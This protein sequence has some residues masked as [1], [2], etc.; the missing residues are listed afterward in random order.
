MTFATRTLRAALAATVMAGGLALSPLAQADDDRHG[1][2]MMQ[3]KMDRDEMREMMRNMDPDQRRQMMRSMRGQRSGMMGQQGGP[4]MMMSGSGMMRG[5]MMGPGMMGG[6]GMMGQ[7]GM[8]GP[9]M[10]GQSGMMGPGMMGG[11][12][13]MGPGMMSGMG[14]MGPMMGGGMMGPGMMQGLSDEKQAELTEMRQDMRRQHMEAML[15]MMAIRDEMQQA[16]VADRPDPARIRELHD[17]MAERHGK[18]LEA[19]I[20]M[21]NQMRDFM[22]T[23]Q[24]EQ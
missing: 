22:D 14:M 15:D 1:Q 10:M 5:Q 23:L 9:G 3:G 12:G 16:M 20:E 17:R 2:G 21:H 4:G 6:M 7:S 13:M 11:S 8:M 19:R 24:D 18:A